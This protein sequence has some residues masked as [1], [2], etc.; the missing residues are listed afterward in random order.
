L[1][2]ITRVNGAVPCYISRAALKNEALNTRLYCINTQCKR[3][4]S[5]LPKY[6][7]IIAKILFSTNGIFAPALAGSSVAA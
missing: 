4:I 2:Q 5:Q 7:A 3:I 6:R 1:Q